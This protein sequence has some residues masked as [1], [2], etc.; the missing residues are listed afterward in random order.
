VTHPLAYDR[1]G[2]PITLAEWSALH[3]IPDYLRVA[4]DE[5]NG[6]QVSTVWM[7]LNYQWDGPPLTFETMVFGGD[8][9]FCARYS[10][11]QQALDGHEATCRMVAVHFP[12][13]R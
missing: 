8:V 1:A 4:L 2:L 11:E 12:P 10:T 3:A 13:Q 5:V 6:M 9:E 7:G